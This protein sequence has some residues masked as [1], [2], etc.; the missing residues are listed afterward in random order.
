MQS[1]YRNAREKKETKR[2]S[3]RISIQDQSGNGTTDRLTTNQNNS[4]TRPWSVLVIVMNFYL[5][6]G[7]IS[8]FPFGWWMHIDIGSAWE[9]SVSQAPTR[10][11]EVHH[12]HISTFRIL[13][14]NVSTSSIALVVACAH[15]QHFTICYIL[16]LLWSQFINS[17]LWTLT[18]SFTWW[19]FGPFLS[20]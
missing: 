11:S 15:F 16:F 4:K 1:S 8:E 12:W 3:V 14:M 13:K 19:C 18:T 2:Q 5:N 9:A 6:V 17:Y 20:G 10:K 7:W